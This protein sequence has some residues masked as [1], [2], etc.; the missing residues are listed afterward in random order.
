MPQPPTKKSKLKI[1]FYASLWLLIAG[2]LSGTIIIQA[3]GYNQYRREL[4]QA[5]ADLEREKQVYNDLLE[6]RVYYESDAYIEQM[7]REQL[8]Y[9]KSDEVVFIN[10]AP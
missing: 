7:A 1:I 3:S 2:I 9:V 4:N 5:L 8:G 6:Q 10:I